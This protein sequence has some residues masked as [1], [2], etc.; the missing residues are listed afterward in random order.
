MFSG[1]SQSRLCPTRLCE[2]PLNETDERSQGND[3]AG[4]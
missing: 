4:E 1:G 3:V 2:P